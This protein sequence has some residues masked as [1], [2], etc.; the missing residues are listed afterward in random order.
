MCDTTDQETGLCLKFNK[1]IVT[2][3]NAALVQLSYLKV[4]GEISVGGKKTTTNNKKELEWLMIVLHLQHF[5]HDRCC[6][7]RSAASCFSCQFSF[8]RYWIFSH[9]SSSNDS[10]LSFSLGLIFTLISSC[11]K[12]KE[13]RNKTI[14]ILSLYAKFCVKFC[15]S[16]LRIAVKAHS[17]TILVGHFLVCNLWQGSLWGLSCEG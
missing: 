4:Q 1:R 12:E 17:C 16:S 8:M 14:F 3:V 11:P 9:F 6:A 7:F 13:K 5:W 15:S 10:C 2:W